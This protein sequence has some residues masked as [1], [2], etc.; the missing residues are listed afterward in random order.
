V[1]KS[2]NT[3]FHGIYFQSTNTC[4]AHLLTHNRVNHYP[5]AIEAAIEAA[6]IPGVTPTYTVV[7]P[8]RPAD[9]ETETVC[10]VYLP[11]TT[12]QEAA[13]RV[14]SSTSISKTVVKHCGARPYKIIPLDE[15]ILQ[16]S[17]LGKL[18]RSKLRK[19]F[20]EGNY[21]E[22]IKANEEIIASYKEHIYEPAT[23]GT[24]SRRLHCCCPFRTL[25]P[26]T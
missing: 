1:S 2:I 18:S 3:Y 25:C 7:F 9:S 4:Q 10:V 19:S 8:H 12:T 11:E 14:N 16:K 6:K 15:T 23:T 13:A 20:E 5:R 24:S 17:S 21:S 22:H 26:M